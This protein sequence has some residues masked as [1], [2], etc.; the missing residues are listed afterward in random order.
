M[1]PRMV[2]NPTRHLFLYL[3]LSLIFVLAA[4]DSSTVT[5]ELEEPSIEFSDSDLFAGVRAGRWRWAGPRGSSPVPGAPRDIGMRCRN[6][7]ATGFGF[8][9]GAKNN[10]LIYLQGGGGCFGPNCAF[11]PSS[12]SETAFY[13]DFVNA[14]TSRNGTSG[15]FSPD[16]PE[17]PFLDWTVV[18]VPY[19][20]G[21]Y[22]GGDTTGVSVPNIEGEQ[23]FV[24][25]RNMDIL[26]DFIA[27]RG[28]TAVDSV[29]LTGTSAGAFGTV[30][31]Y[32]LVADRL[33]PA[34][35]HYLGDSGPFLEPDSVLAPEL[36]QFWRDLWN[37]DSR[38]IFPSVIPD[39]CL[40]CAQ[41]N[42]DGLENILPHYAETNP[43]RFFG[44]F[45][46]TAD[47]G[48]RGIF[49]ND[50]ASCTTPDP[51]CTDI[52][53]RNRVDAQAYEDA[54]FSLRDVFPP[55]VGTFYAGGSDHTAVQTNNLYGVSVDT[56]SLTDWIRTGL[57]SMAT[58]VPV[59][60]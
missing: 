45:S 37:L 34:P 27:A 51:V 55:N 35:V 7:S 2:P 40:D 6:G 12:A 8:R 60:Q 30:F 48:I 26:L 59:V 49:C 44:L 52:P 13:N 20:T 46:F 14:T 53:I 3:V 41:P 56:T 1:I 32:G 29:V 15:I 57:D 31:T 54:L 18:F 10:L 23:D 4:C 28:A 33:A 43:D 21:D 47:C 58:N 9:P 19:C 17:N 16:N 39:G 36:Q 11:T 50:N 25:Y 42:G 5:G 22:H 24:G 38:A